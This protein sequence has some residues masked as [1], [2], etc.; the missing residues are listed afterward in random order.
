[1]TKR[2]RCRDFKLWRE[3]KAA[4]LTGLGEDVVNRVHFLGR[5]KFSL[6]ALVAGLATLFTTARFL[7]CLGRTGWIGRRRSGGVGGISGQPGDDLFEFDDALFEF[8][9]FP[10]GIA[11]FK[12]VS[13]TASLPAS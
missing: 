8:F 1:M 3:R 2:V 10:K 12:R 13:I 5:Q 4:V 6:L 7:F 9:Q 11:I